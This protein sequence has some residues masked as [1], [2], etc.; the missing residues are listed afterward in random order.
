MEEKTINLFNLSEKETVSEYLVSSIPSKPKDLDKEVGAI[1]KALSKA[2]L[3]SLQPSI[4]FKFNCNFQT[5]LFPLEHDLRYGVSIIIPKPH[6]VTEEVLEQFSESCIAQVNAL[7]ELNSALANICKKDGDIPGKYNSE[8]WIQNNSKSFDPSFRFS[9][10]HLVTE[11]RKT[12]ILKKHIIELVLKNN[13]KIELVI[14]PTTT[15]PKRTNKIQKYNLE[16]LTIT[17][18]ECVLEAQIDGNAYSVKVDYP[19]E[20]INQLYLAFAEGNWIK[21]SAD[22]ID[23]FLD[24]NLIRDRLE[25]KEFIDFAENQTK[26]MF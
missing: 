20:L 8:E 26:A 14:P 7:K 24:G 15:Q 18:K 1:F 11:I 10:K 22:S 16:I 4:P 12:P 9:L 2:Y 13:E 5:N 6:V 3:K 25:I 17:R 23:S 21:V 19:P